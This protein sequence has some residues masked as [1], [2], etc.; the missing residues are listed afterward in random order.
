MK[1]ANRPLSP[2]LQIYDLT[3]FSSLMSTL[4]RISGVLLGAGLLL[5]VAWLVFVASGEARFNQIN[6]F[7]S[8]EFIVLILFCWS[9]LLLLHL[10]NGIR[11]LVWDTGRG[12][13]LPIAKLS[14]RIAAFSALG[15]NIIFWLF[16]SF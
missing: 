4:Q 11:Y 5:V 10:C 16:L 6:H 13:D 8:N 7:F 15:I 3:R 14:A 1:Q 12:F 9:G 2:H